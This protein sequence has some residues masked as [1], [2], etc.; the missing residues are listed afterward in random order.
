MFILRQITKE[1]SILNH[2][3]GDYYNLVKKESQEKEFNK[4]LEL[5]GNHPYIDKIFGV[6]R[7]HSHSS[8]E[9]YPLY[10][11]QNYYIMTESGQTFEKIKS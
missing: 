5:M 10:K 4:E 9:H 1:G 8:T 7:Y 11:G 3:I 6:I 2:S